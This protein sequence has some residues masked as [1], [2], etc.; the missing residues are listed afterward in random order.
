LGK[1]NDLKKGAGVIL[2]ENIPPAKKHFKLDLL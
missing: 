1:E 2:Q